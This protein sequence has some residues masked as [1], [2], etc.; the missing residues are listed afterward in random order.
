MATNIYVF[1]YSTTDWVEAFLSQTEM[2]QVVAK[3][4]IT[5]IIPRGW[6]DGSEVKSIAKVLSSIPSNHMVADNHL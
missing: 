3:K 5:K 2:A 4:L 1:V 6:R